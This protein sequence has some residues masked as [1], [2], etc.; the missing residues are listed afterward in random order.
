MRMC[1]YPHIGDALLKVVTQGLN[2]KYS[3]EMFGAGLPTVMGWHDLGCRLISPG[4]MG[5]V[6]SSG[7]DR[8][9]MLLELRGHQSDAGLIFKSETG[10][11]ISSNNFDARLTAKLYIIVICKIIYNF[12]LCQIYIYT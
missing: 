1:F 5:R 12:I 6:H 8:V 4:L 9:F 2:I 7:H 10:F 11:L 3:S